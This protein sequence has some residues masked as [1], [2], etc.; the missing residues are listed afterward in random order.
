MSC[1]LPA[2]GRKPSSLAL[3]G[4]GLSR[5]SVFSFLGDPPPVLR[6]HIV[7]ISRALKS[8]DDVWRLHRAH[9]ALSVCGLGLPETSARLQLQS[10]HKADAG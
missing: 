3:F 10:K 7:F 1:A 5:R 8:P 6:L 4:L 9:P 2:A